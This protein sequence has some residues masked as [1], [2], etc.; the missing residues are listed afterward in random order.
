MFFI[1]VVDS[2]NTFTANS[3]HLMHPPIFMPPQL[4]QFTDDT[5]IIAEGHPLILM[6]IA[7]ILKTYE[8]LTRLKINSNKSVFLT[9]VIPQ[10]LMP[11]IA[12]ILSYHVSAFSISYLGLPL[13]TKRLNK[14]Q[15]QPLLLAVKQKL[16]GW[17]ADLLSYGGRVTL[18]KAVL[19]AM[20]LHF[21]QAIRI[22]KGVIKHID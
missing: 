22:P 21:A 8:K 9:I 17:K 20:P 2:F 6:I 14:E 12:N 11:A 16:A 13:T 1:M 10:N 4:I 15:F 3:N 18:V 19:S 5:I 7:K